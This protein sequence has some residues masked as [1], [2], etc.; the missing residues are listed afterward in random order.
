M[1][2]FHYWKR[3]LLYAEVWEN[4][5][6]KVGERFGVSNVTIAKL[7]RRLKV[8]VP[9]R[10]YW[11]RK[12]SGK[13]VKQ[14]PL[15]PFK[16]PPMIV[17]RRNVS[18]PKP[19]IGSSD[20]ELAKIAEVESRNLSNP[21]SE[22]KLIVKARQV[23]ERARTD[24]YDRA[25]HAPSSPCLDVRVSRGLLDRALSIMNA[26]V[27][28]LEAEGLGLTVSDTTISVEVFGQSI[29]F[30]I[31][32]ELR[33]KERREVKSYFSTRLEKIYECSGNLTFRV[34]TTAAGIRACWS[35]GKR[36]SLE[37]HLP[38]LI[39]GILRNARSLRIEQEVRKQRELEWERQSRDEV[40]RIR[41]TGEEQQRFENLVKCVNDW[42][43]A[44]KIR[45]FVNAYQKMSEER[46]EP[47]TPESPRGQWLAWARR[48]ADQL[49]PLQFGGNPSTHSL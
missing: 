42:E 45:T 18:T 12:A 38:K 47:T 13:D 30:G 44:E 35:D 8:P 17:Y 9:E 49:D 31:E 22:H 23:L 3:E 27:F 46:G 26:L 20:P 4:P 2:D 16:N 33:L 32:E 15:P 37:E 25:V 6:T 48:K 11:A 36:K 7:C 19:E 24:K 21:T 14:M 39:G 43:K 5:A 29:S 41:K 1:S 34:S 40:E 28:A 10:G